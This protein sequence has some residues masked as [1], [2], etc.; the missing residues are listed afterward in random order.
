MDERRNIIHG[1]GIIIKKVFIADI[2]L[3]VP[4]ILWKNEFHRADC[5]R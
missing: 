5:Q 1:D 4:E 2:I 3:D